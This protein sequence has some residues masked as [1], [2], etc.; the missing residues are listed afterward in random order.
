MNIPVVAAGRLEWLPPVSKPGDRVALRAEFD[1]LVVF[2]ACPMDILPI[3]GA[4]CVP[5]AAHFSIQ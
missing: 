2:S 5:T 3:N 4:G 1:C